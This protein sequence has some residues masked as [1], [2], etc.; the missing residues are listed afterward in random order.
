VIAEL[1]RTSEGRNRYRAFDRSRYDAALDGVTDAVHVSVLVAASVAIVAAGISL[2]GVLLL[3]VFEQRTIIALK[4]AVG[5]RRFDIVLE[6]VL[7]VAVVVIMGT[8]I[9][10]LIGGIVT[11]AVS[12]VL[13]PR[14]VGFSVTT[15]WSTMAAF[16]LVCALLLGVPVA[17][18]ASLLAAR[19]PPAQLMGGGMRHA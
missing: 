5:A 4:R 12:S 13:F 10:G 1:E 2:F 14:I 16:A 7:Q 9:G 18:V 8:M 3:S 17:V 11:T 15:P 6:T 19:T